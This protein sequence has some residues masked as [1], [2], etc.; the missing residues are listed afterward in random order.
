M[1]ISHLKKNSDFS[2]L[3][4]RNKGRSL[5]QQ[6]VFL[7]HVMTDLKTTFTSL[8]LGKKFEC[9]E[10]KV[11]S[12][13]CWMVIGILLLTVKGFLSAPINNEGEPNKREKRQ[14]EKT[15]KTGEEERPDLEPGTPS[16]ETF[17]DKLDKVSKL[18][19]EYFGI[20][21]QKME[22][23]LWISVA[24]V[25]V[26]TFLLC[27]VLYLICTSFHLMYKCVCYKC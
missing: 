15:G 8:L 18:L 23:D 10:R 27:C 14:V 17:R 21:M 11:R 24:I 6:C 13:M 9:F 12:V 26:S 19:Q 4:L 3:V 20:F 16:D 22:S 1:I 2:N 5:S 7:R 25:F